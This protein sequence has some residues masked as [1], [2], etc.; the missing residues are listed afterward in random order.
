MIKALTDLCKLSMRLKSKLF[1]HVGPI[2]V[3]QVIV[4]MP[5]QTNNI[6]LDPID[7]NDQ[8][9]FTVDNRPRSPMM[10]VENF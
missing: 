9:M 5:S 6:G 2:E 7:V 3:S 10:I 1:K 4:A 8:S